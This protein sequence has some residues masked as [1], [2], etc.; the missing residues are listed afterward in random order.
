MIDARSYY[1]ALFR[2]GSKSYLVYDLQSVY[3]KCIP[4]GEKFPVHVALHA[5]SFS[6]ILGIDTITEIGLCIESNIA[7]VFSRGL[8]D[9]L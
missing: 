9:K 2:H 1:E 5:F 4:Y 8:W 6:S 3:T 7:L